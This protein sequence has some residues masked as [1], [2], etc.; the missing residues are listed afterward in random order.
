LASDY[1]TVMQTGLDDHLGKIVA[2]RAFYDASHEVDAD[3]FA[4][5]TKQIT[6]GYQAD[7]AR[8]SRG[9]AAGLEPPRHPRSTR[10]V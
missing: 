2:V 3:E 4:V 8:L 1:A 10:R 9:D 6:Q 5:F 7:H